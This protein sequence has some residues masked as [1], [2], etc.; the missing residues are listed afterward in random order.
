MAVAV[1]LVGT[2][3]C[4]PAAQPCAVDDDCEASDVCD[5]GACRATVCGDGIAEG[6]EACDDAE[7][8]GATAPC[9]LS[10][11]RNVCGDGFVEQGREDCDDGDPDGG[12]CPADCQQAV[13]GDGL[14]E[15]DEGCDLGEDNDD[16]GAC[17]TACQ[18]PGCGDGRV[19][20]DVEEC[21][22]GDDNADDAACRPGCVA[23]ACGDG[24]VHRGFEECDDGDDNADDAACTT[25]CRTAVCGDG[26]TRAGSEQC[27][28]GDDNADDAACTTACRTAVCGDG[29]VH[30]G[31]EACDDGPA[32]GPTARCLPTCVLNVCGDGFVRAGIEGCDLGTANSDTGACT[33]ACLQPGCGDGLLLGGVEEC[34]DGPANGPTAACLPD[35]TDNV[36]GDGILLAGVEQCDEGAAN[37][38]A[39]HCL[40]DCTDNVCGDGI[41]DPLDEECDDGNRVA[42]DGCSPTCSRTLWRLPLLAPLTRG[43]GP[44]SL[45][46]VAPVTELIVFGTAAGDVVAVRVVDGREAWRADAGGPVVSVVA[47]DARVAVAT[48]AGDVLGFDAAPTSATLRFKKTGV[49]I[50]G[51]AARLAL[52]EGRLVVVTPA[53][54]LR[55][56]DTAGEAPTLRTGAGATYTASSTPVAATCDPCAPAIVTGNDSARPG[57]VTLPM[58]TTLALWDIQTGCAPSTTPLESSERAVGH[59]VVTHNRASV[60]TSDGDL[61]RHIFSG[62]CSPVASV[63]RLEHDFTTEPLAFENPDLNDSTTYVLTDRG[64]RVHRFRMDGDEPVT[65]AAGWPALLPAGRLSSVPPAL[66]ID[67][68]VVVVDDVGEVHAFTATGARRSLGSVGGP[69]T[70]GPLLAARAVIVP[71]ASALVALEGAPLPATFDGWLRDGGN[72]GGSASSLCAQG[73]AAAA[74]APLLLLGA[75]WAGRRRRRR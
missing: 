18:P 47:E 66:D 20:P 45:R 13:C 58:G 69:A 36:C 8:N 42:L 51:G 16:D 26:V 9:L 34:D 25:A 72:A 6:A 52:Q 67:R 46:V 10:C 64:G 15:G 48:E 4:A 38:P 5:R 53:R 11:V 50:A 27:D 62:S 2:A 17:T 43:A 40:A 23:A 57:A 49:A 24:V 63:R 41:L 60:V 55:F 37:G 59:I 70:A 28:D 35:C 71:T 12:D 14:I 75:L 68:G 30:A 65:H 56:F 7:N 1:A 44:V 54:A 33:T 21:D 22:D 74:T 3:A 73:S 31:V 19:Q 61:V 39:A 29:L 32:N